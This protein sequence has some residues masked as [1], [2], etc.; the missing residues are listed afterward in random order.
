MR[1][2]GVWQALAGSACTVTQV[3]RHI[4]RRL[5]GC[6]LI[7][8]MRSQ[9]LWHAFQ[10]GYTI[11]ERQ[12]QRQGLLRQGR[13]CR[14]LRRAA[15]L[16]PT[17]TAHF[18]VP[19]LQKDLNAL[20]EQRQFCLGP[21]PRAMQAVGHVTGG[22]DLTGEGGRHGRRGGGRGTASERRGRGPVRY[23][24]RPPHPPVLQILRSGF[25]Q[26]SG[27]LAHY[28]L[29]ASQAHKQSDRVKIKEW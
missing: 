14:L 2:R 4:G 17:L 16:S 9:S 21:A 15:P 24:W 8:S 3:V 19:G 1:R 23:R 29:V 27:A 5:C 25:P 28:K 18:P 26:Q 10:R 11:F 6:K 20:G 22:H 13:A 7:R 12:R